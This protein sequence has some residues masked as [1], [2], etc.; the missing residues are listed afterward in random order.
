MRVQVE[1]LLHA[2]A[3]Q[4]DNAL[5]ATKEKINPYDVDD[6][7]TVLLGQ[8]ETFQD[9]TNKNAV[10]VMENSKL[11]MHLSFMPVQYR[12][13]VAHIQATNGVLYQTQR[14]DPKAIIPQEDH[15]AGGNIA[16]T[17]A[18]MSH[19]SVQ[20]C[21]R[22]ANYTSFLLAKATLDQRARISVRG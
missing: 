10:L 2:N 17:N 22:D 16:L 6:M 11:R 4:I 21:L 13:F 18:P 15:T 3:L 5:L 20:E 8:K 7:R 1:Q 14:R 12:D 9:L 19:S